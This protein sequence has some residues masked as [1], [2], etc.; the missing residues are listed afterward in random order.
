ML[1]LMRVI[2]HAWQDFLHSC[3]RLY[4]LGVR[5]SEIVSRRGTQ[6]SMRES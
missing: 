6:R 2:L 4:M 5:A 3:G 1:S